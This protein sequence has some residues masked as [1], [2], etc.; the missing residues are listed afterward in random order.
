MRK[1]I[2]EPARVDLS[3]TEGAG[4]LQQRFGVDCV[5]ANQLDIVDGRL[6]GVRNREWLE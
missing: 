1:S 3:A 2:E 6:L 5:S 4:H